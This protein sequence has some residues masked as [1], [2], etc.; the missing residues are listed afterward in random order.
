MVQHPL[1]K[2]QEKNRCLEVSSLLVEQSAHATL[3]PT[4]KCLL[5]LMLF[6]LSGSMSNNQ[7]KTF[8]FMTH[9]LFQIHANG[10]GVLAP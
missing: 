7:A 1:L 8:N 2:L 9:L 10:V 4:L 3:L 6:V 5:F